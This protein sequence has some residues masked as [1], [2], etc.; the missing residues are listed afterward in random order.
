MI[1]YDAGRRDVAGRTLI[2]LRCS[3]PVWTA[4][5]AAHLSDLLV[6]CFASSLSLSSV[7]MFSTILYVIFYILFVFFWFG[8]I[9]VWT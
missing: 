9:P 1:V 4:I 2:L 3:S 5:N 6:Y 7:F 8:M